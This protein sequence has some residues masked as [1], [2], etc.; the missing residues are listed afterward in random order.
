[1][2]KSNTVHVCS[3]GQCLTHLLLLKM[4]EERLRLYQ[5]YRRAKSKKRREAAQ[6]AKNLHMKTFKEMSSRLL[7]PLPKDRTSDLEAAESPPKVKRT[8]FSNDD[9]AFKSGSSRRGR[10][11]ENDFSDDEVIEAKE[12]FY[13]YRQPE[14]NKAHWETKPRP[15]L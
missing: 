4:D 3:S 10:F 5:E 11:Y 7:P 9:I 2:Q 14:L 15:Y 6:A 8:R 13:L 1:M 12:D